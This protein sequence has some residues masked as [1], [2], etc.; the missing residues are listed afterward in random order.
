M[1]FLLL[2]SFLFMLYAPP[3][4]LIP[5]LN[6]IRPVQLAGVAAIALLT[7]RKTLWGETWRFVRPEGLYMAMLLI[8]SALSCLGAFWPRLAFESTLDLAKVALIYFAIVNLVDTELRMKR[9][10][11]VLIVAGIVP[12]VFA[13]KNYLQG[14]FIEGNRAAWMGTWGNPN[15]LAYGLVI[16]I[17]IAFQISRITRWIYRPIFWGITALYF[18]G[19]FVAH[20]RGGMIGACAVLL[21]LGLRQEGVG[22]KAFTIAALIGVLIF[23]A[24]YW[25]RDDGFDDIRSDFTAQQR[26]ETIKAGLRMFADHPFLGV[27][28]GC[29]VVA[30]SFFAPSDLA[31]KDSLVIH[32]TPI[33]ALSELGLLGFL[34]FMLLLVAAWVHVRQMARSSSGLIRTYAVAFEASLVGFVACGMFGGY[35]LSWYPYIV[36]GLISA[37]T[38]FKEGKRDVHAVNA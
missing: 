15:D 16:L 28:L 19:I 2:T 7:M 21:I 10:T 11:L 31:F 30:W 26:I 32:N 38:C 13:V 36:I 17:P 8:A 14:N 4:N 22:A 9:V 18:A 6:P 33:Q 25:G 3:A 35:V 5:A 27:G 23:G 12:A 1:P 34:P 20:S 29:S 24:F 37:L